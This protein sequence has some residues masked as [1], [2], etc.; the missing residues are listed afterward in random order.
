VVPTAVFR[1]IDKQYQVLAVNA[2]A[3]FVDMQY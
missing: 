3:A 2:G 1:I